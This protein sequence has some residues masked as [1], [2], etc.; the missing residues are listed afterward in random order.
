M[1]FYNNPLQTLKDMKP[2]TYK[3]NVFHGPF[4]ARFFV[5]IGKLGVPYVFATDSL[6]LHILTKFAQYME[7]WAL[8]LLE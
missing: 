8:F 4:G 3:K 5:K 2:Q 7:Q 1:T 6:K